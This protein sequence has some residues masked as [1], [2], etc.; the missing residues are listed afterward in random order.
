MTTTMPSGDSPQKAQDYYHYLQSRQLEPHGRVETWHVDWNALLW[1]WGFVIVLAILL[2]LWVWQY[3]TTRTR[4]GISPID[5]WG[6]YTTERAVHVPWFFYF[7][8]LVTVVFGG[9]MVIGHLING[10]LF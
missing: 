8:T 9:V 6:G 2:L 1:D 4:G 10:Q 3:R 5:T 7:V